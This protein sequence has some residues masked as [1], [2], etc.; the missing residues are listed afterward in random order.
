MLKI[1]QNR[2]A[3]LANSVSDAATCWLGLNVCKTLDVLYRIAD[4]ANATITKANTLPSENPK[5][6]SQQ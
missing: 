3:I 4:P 5:M 1:Y 6:H 2:R